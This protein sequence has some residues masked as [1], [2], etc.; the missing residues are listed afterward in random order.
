[1][2]RDLGILHQ[3]PAALYCDNRAALHIAANPVFHERTRHIEM[4]CHYIRDKIQ[5]GSV[6]TKFV[7]SANQLADVLTKPLGK[8][9]FVPMIRKLGVQDIHSPT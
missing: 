3:E 1:L 6:A 2:L 5:D 9:L 7:K 4:D 8:E